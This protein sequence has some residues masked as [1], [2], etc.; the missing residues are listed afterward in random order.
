MEALEFVQ[1]LLER[2]DNAG[3]YQGRSQ[4]PQR[5]AQIFISYERTDQAVANKLYEALPK[6]RFEVWLDTTFLQGG[7]DWNQELEDKIK[8]S[9]IFLV[10]N[11]KNLASKVIGFVNKEIDTA[12]DL[13]K[14]R[15]RGIEFVVPLL[16]DGT[17][18]E[19]GLKELQRFHQ[20][21]LRR[22]SFDTDIAQ[23]IKRISRDLQRMTRDLKSEAL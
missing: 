23:I 20:L 10:L 12:L 17:L 21:P 3:G 9:D 4:R 2:L 11:S 1:Q 18:A 16:I 5:R 19:E 8:A 15:Q 7:E 14:Y 13:Q 6:D 22:T